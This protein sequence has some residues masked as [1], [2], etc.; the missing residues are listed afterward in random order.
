[1]WKPISASF[2]QL[3]AAYAE[4]NSC[5]AKEGRNPKAKE[6]ACVIVSTCWTLM[7]VGCVA[8]AQFWVHLGGNF[9]LLYEK[10]DI[11][12]NIKNF[13][14]KKISVNSNCKYDWRISSDF[15][16]LLFL[17][18]KLFKIFKLMSFSKIS[19]FYVKQRKMILN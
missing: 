9:Y 3:R 17:N 12:D 15:F 8:E 7:K 2:S 19:F 5:E 16:L 13:I 11:S 1:M 4:R 10:Y 14:L 18:K 6:S